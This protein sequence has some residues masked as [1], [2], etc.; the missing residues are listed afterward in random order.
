MTLASNESSRGPE[1]RAS[2]PRVYPVG[3]SLGPSVMARNA[4]AV[5]ALRPRDHRALRSSAAIDPPVT[6]TKIRTPSTRTT[7]HASRQPIVAMNPA[8][9]A[10]LGVMRTCMTTGALCGV[11]RAGVAAV[12]F[13][14]GIDCRRKS[15]NANSSWS[16]LFE[17][18]MLTPQSAA[19]VTFLFGWYVAILLV[20]SIEIFLDR[21]IDQ[22]RT[23]ASGFVLQRS[24][25][26][27]N[28]RVDASAEKRL[29]CPPWHR[30]E[31]VTSVSQAGKNAH[32]CIT[33]TSVIL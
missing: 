3:R 31:H 27:K 23:A 19:G 2:N 17:L 8:W 18:V 20:L 16:G 21:S 14:G 28:L 26:L 4:A 22:L 9:I 15:A 7:N 30:R 13:S 24:Q 33:N 11:A 6:I 12:G 29:R 25:S 32:Y 5:P 10:S 1:C